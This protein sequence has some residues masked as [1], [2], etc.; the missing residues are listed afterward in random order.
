MAD[1]STPMSVASASSMTLSMMVEDA[2]EESS[3][4]TAG[5]FWW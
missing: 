5:R 3:E 4:D 1:E 2:E